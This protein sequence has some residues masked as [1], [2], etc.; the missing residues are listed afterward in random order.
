MLC[1]LSDELWQR[2]LISCRI[3]F[4]ACSNMYLS[5]FFLLFHSLIWRWRFIWDI[6]SLQCICFSLLLLFFALRRK[7]IHKIVL[8]HFLF[9]C[10]SSAAWLSVLLAVLWINV[11][12]SIVCW[13]H[14][15]TQTQIY[16]TEIHLRKCF[17]KLFV[18]E[19][20]CWNKSIHTRTQTSSYTIMHAFSIRN[21][22][23]PQSEH[24][25]YSIKNN[26][27]ERK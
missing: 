5:F 20:M 24:P 16:T 9:D 10:I 27:I 23:C 7:K 18:C 21:T 13:K 25:T 4:T 15:N 22:Q 3:P 14:T 2:S 17:R 8:R 19:V 26:W 1:P 12:Y 11:C 6:I